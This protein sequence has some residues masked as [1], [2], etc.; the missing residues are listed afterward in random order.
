MKKKL[1]YWKILALILLIIEIGFVVWVDKEKVKEN[2]IAWRL[3]A[4]CIMCIP[5]NIMFIYAKRTG[6]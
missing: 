4:G 5:V 3:Y 6:M 2:L 1:N